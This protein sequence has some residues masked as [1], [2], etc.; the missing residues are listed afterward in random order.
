LAKS[1]TE[2]MQDYMESDV[3][4]DHEDKIQLPF[5]YGE[6]K[7][8]MHIEM[9]KLLES[10]KDYLIKNDEFIE[11]NCDCNELII[12]A[13]GVEWKNIQAK[14]VIFCEG[15]ST[16]Q[17][18]YFNWLPFVPAKG[19]IL[20]VKIPKLKMNQMI[21]KGIFVLPV[22]EEIY[23]VGSTFDWDDLSNDPTEKAKTHLIEKL[24]DLLKINYEIIDHKAGV[25]PT[26]KD[27]RPFI[28]IHPNHQE[29]GVFNGM[30]TKGALLA[31][32]YAKQFVEHLENNTELD[33]EVN[34]L[35]YF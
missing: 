22:G 35:R 34:I 26:V 31:P 20:L 18:P 24:D 7:G 15:V 16:Q 14:C 30:G 11:D 4:H 6:I 29:V 32:F 33:P 2:E 12:T 21:N 3:V 28:G 27:R 23:K 17:N 8:G 13:N 19:E 1:E 5:G 25:R 9:S 10:Y